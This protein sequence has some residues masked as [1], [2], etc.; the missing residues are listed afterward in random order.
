MDIDWKGLESFSKDDFNQ[1]MAVD[2]EL[3]K[4]ELLGHEE[5]FENLYDRIPKEFLFMKELLLSALWRSP[6]KWSQAPENV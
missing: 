3:W 2:R 5:L 6:E 4:Q 1:I